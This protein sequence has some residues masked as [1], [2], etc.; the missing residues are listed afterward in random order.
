VSGAL[1]LLALLT[2]GIV[3]A[4]SLLATAPVTGFSAGRIQSGDRPIRL[5][6]GRARDQAVAIAK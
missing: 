3:V 1:I 6:A 4:R 2:N 5:G